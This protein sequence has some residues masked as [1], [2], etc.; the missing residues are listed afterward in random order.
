MTRSRWSKTAA[1]CIP[2]SPQLEISADGHELEMAA[3][4]TGFLADMM[5]N[6]NMA[7]GRT[8]DISFSL[9]AS[10]ELSNAPGGERRVGQ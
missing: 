8:I 7:L 6:P 1:Q 3:P 10:G 4:F 5:A 2:A 9:E